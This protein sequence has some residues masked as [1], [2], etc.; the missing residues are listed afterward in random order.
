MSNEAG[1][2]L[3][4]ALTRGAKALVDGIRLMRDQQY[5]V[6]AHEVN[7]ARNAGFELRGKLSLYAAAD[8][9]TIG[10]PVQYSDYKG[11]TLIPVNIEVRLP[12]IKMHEK[13]RV[14]VRWLFQSM[15]FTEESQRLLEHVKR[16]MEAR[17]RLEERTYDL[18]DYLNR[19]HGGGGTVL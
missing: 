3:G 8:G 2:E 19:M 9:E 1:R 10:C 4:L 13:P 18:Q 14:L 15:F 12:A 5:Q 17:R 11:R 16:I 7:L 6:L